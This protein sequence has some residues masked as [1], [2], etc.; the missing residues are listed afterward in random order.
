MIGDLR[1]GSIIKGL[2]IGER[3]R[4]KSERRINLL[5][6]LLYTVNWHGTVAIS[7]CTVIITMKTH[8]CGGRGEEKVAK[9]GR[10]GGGR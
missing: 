9:E 2:E 3:E 6:L 4:W 10:S 7:H 1:G 8:L 5:S